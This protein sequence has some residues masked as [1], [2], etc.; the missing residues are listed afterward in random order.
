MRSTG[1]GQRRAAGKQS[2]GAAA[3][4]HPRAEHS[5]AGTRG[6]SGRAL[7]PCGLAPREGDAGA[8]AG[9]PDPRLVIDWYAKHA[10]PLPWRALGTTPYAVLISEVMSQQTPVARVIPA[11]EEWMRRWPNADSLASAPPAE[12]LMVW[13]RLGYPRRALRL[14]EMAQ[15]VVSQHDGELPRTREELLALPGVGDYTAGAVLAFAYGQRALALDTNV[16]RVLSRAVAGRA[17][18][19]PSLN[20]AEREMAESLLPDAGPMERISGDSDGE[21]G[22]EDTTSS[23]SLSDGA[24]AAKGRSAEV[25]PATWVV[26][27]MELGA[28]VCTARDPQCEVCPWQPQC[29]WVSAG[30][31]ADEHAGQRRTQAWQGTDRQA[32]GKV[33]AALR[34]A[35]P[36]QALARETLLAAATLGPRK[37]VKRDSQQPERAVDSLATDRLIVT[38]DAGATYRLP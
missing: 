34:E 31:P 8:R 17:L 23:A 2:D 1:S 5:P 14:I 32:R 9:A 36:G 33:M 13:G 4:S 38:D 18:P 27:V 37:G 26:A 11:W 22:K 6:E 29:A 7:P 3:S 15:A 16:R 21:T 12:V 10:R 24:E 19:P 25:D 20:K 35:G 28:L 30:K